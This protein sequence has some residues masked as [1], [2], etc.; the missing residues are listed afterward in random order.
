MRL[1]SRP[2][3]I[4]TE[5][6][7]RLAEPLTTSAGDHDA[8]LDLV[9]DASHVLIG[10]ASHG[11]H[12][13][14]A[15]RAAL[16]RRLIDDHGFSAV[17]IE[18]DWPDA[19]RVNEF[20]LGGGDDDTA[21]AALAG[22]VRFPTWMWRN[23]EVRDFVTWLRE[24][25]ASQ[26]P[27]RRAGFYGLDLYS[28][29]ASMQSVLSYLE[30]V[31]PE[32]ARRARTRYACFDHFGED[33][34]TY[35]YAVAAEMA[36]P[37]EQEAVRQLVEL[38]A[39]VHDLL[40][41]DGRPA[42]D[43]FFSA[44]QNA[45]LV[46]NA[47][48]Y[49]RAMYRGRQSSWNLRDRHMAD[50]MDAV[51]GHLAATGREPR[52]VVWAHNSHLGDARHTDMARRG[53][54]NLGQLARERHGDGVRLIGFST[55]TGTVTAAQDWDEPGL[56]RRVRPSLEGSWE[57]L[58]HDV[59]AEKDVPRFVVITRGNPL[60]EE[61]LQGRRP[62]RAIGVI[63]RPETERASHY[64]DVELVRE[65]DA[66]IHVDETTALRGLEPGHRWERGVEELPET[67]PT[68]L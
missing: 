19:H 29:F 27:A 32:A 59:A 2:S 5:D 58:F 38:R 64:Y 3:R 15:E 10:E 11:T 62:Q 39:R 31:D 20:V 47:E 53:E 60:A 44:E 49:Y 40:G 54:H 41:H 25:N 52:L 61:V 9:G 4:R 1:S 22:F 26:P 42:R 12:E 21:D 55:H 45:R 65:F 56:R 68:G 50:T 8:L 16:T 33:S 67:Y 43:R 7:A 37:C 13:F 28:M 35:G 30:S 57:R 48:H 17:C 66:I 18:G 6:L 14:Y 23:T 34:Q 36:E 46:A 24:R 51:A 63:Y